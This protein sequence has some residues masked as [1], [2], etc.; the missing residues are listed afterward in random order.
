MA[1]MKVSRNSEADRIA[2]GALFGVWLGALIVCALYLAF[3]P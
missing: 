3:G 1:G 2:I